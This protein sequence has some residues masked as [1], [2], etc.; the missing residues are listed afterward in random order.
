MSKDYSDCQ[1]LSEEFKKTSVKL[2]ESERLNRSKSYFLAQAVHDLRQPLHAQR[3]FLQ[4]LKDSELN[5]EQ[6]NLADKCA[7]ALENMQDLMDNYLDLSRLD[8]GGVKYEP[9]IF[10]LS[11]LTD[12]LAEEF[13]IIAHSQNKDFHYISCALEINTDRILLERMLRNLLSNAI[14]YGKDKILFGCKRRGKGVQII[15][16]DN[17]SGISGHDIP[18]IFDE[19]YQSGLNPE[20]KKNG[21]G[22]GLAIVKKISDIIHAKIQVETQKGK[23]TSFSFILKND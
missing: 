14:K 2:I 8:Y 18:Y 3:I 12:K 13:S 15:V 10:Q 23:G 1:E 9:E 17:G 20:N 19:F 11:Q 21:A 6:R 7:L 4:L 22:L 5:S 16:I